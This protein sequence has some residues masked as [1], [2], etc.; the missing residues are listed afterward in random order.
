MPSRAQK[1][2]AAAALVITVGLA[3][4]WASRRLGDGPATVS[5][6]GAIEATQV[7]ISPR[8]TARIVERTV[9]EGQPV[10][11]PTPG[12]AGR[13]AAHRRAETRRRFRKQLD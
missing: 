2:A 5:V 3:V 1:L 8:I 12:A 6:T 9:H 11:R 13:P 10:A 4:T 7:D